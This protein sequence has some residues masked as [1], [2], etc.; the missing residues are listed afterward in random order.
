MQQFL[1][2]KSHPI[3]FRTKKATLVTNVLECAC[4]S[5]A[6][7]GLA[8]CE[9]QAGL[10]QLD[11]LHSNGMEGVRKHTGVSTQQQEAGGGSQEAHGE[12][13]YAG[14]N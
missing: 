3:L 10:A 7:R 11:C 1:Q 5:R 4:K 14:A 6:L 2:S 8:S 13:E 9:Q 12:D